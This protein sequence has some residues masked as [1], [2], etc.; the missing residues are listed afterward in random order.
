MLTL[1]VSEFT[2]ICNKQ[3]H[4]AHV[5]RIYGVGYTVAVRP[6]PVRQCTAATFEASASSQASSEVHILNKSPKGGA[7]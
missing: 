1:R 5:A 3:A 6:F 2:G 4:E 7:G